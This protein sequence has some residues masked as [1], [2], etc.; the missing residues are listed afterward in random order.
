MYIPD[1]F[2]GFVHSGVID[3]STPV[4]ARGSNDNLEYSLADVQAYE[5][6]GTHTQFSLAKSS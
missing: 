4:L 3:S 1:L 2:G 6:F 5:N